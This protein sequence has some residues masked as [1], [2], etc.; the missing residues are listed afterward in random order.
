MNKDQFIAMIKGDGHPQIS[1]YPA[2]SMLSH[3]YPW[4][5]AIQIVK[6]RILHDEKSTEYLEQLKL[7]SALTSDRKQLYRFIMQK[8]LVEKLIALDE[9]ITTELNS[10]SEI[11][12]IPENERVISTISADVEPLH[13][14]LSDDILK[15]ES[16][17]PVVENNEKIVTSDDTQKSTNNLVVV[18]KDILEELI[19]RKINEVIVPE[20]KEKEQE[21]NS[22][23]VQEE[24]HSTETSEE[25]IISNEAAEKENIAE[26]YDDLEKQFL[27]EAVNAT[28]QVDVMKDLEKLPELEVENPI[29]S[30]KIQTLRPQKPSEKPSVEESFNWEQPHSFLNW[31]VPKKEDSE[32][33]NSIPVEDLVEQFLKNDPKITPQKVEFYT[34]G[35]VAKLSIA[36]NEDFVSETLASIYEKQGYYAKAIRVYEKLSLKIPG[37]SAYFAS[38]I[39]E[40]ESLKNNKTK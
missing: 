40:L 38:R 35:N 30:P 26:H 27:W 34:P 25:I 20:K 28:I 9:E 15:E 17:Q 33:K 21:I 8:A 16:E 18:T 3:K 2:I 24:F 31:L 19:E 13:F 5:Q 39:K 22:L 1:H 11:K 32:G 29:E 23:T 10:E 4:S 12:E 36:D 14:K 7:T 37:K 6:T